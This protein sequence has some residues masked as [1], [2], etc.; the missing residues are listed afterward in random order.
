MNICIGL[1]GSNLLSK[2]SIVKQCF[3]F[4]IISDAIVFCLNSCVFFFV[5]SVIGFRISNIVKVHKSYEPLY[6]S[7]HLRL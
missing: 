1:V 4:L 5:R 2:G 6:L 7:E 3:I